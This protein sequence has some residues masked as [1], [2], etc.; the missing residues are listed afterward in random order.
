M[1]EFRNA[2]PE[3]PD[4]MLCAD[5]G[6]CLGDDH[7]YQICACEAGKR[8][9]LADPGAADRANAVRDKVLSIGA[10]RSA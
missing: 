4:C 6:L 2:F 5:K 9:G 8:L 7:P 3:Y 10:K 1:A